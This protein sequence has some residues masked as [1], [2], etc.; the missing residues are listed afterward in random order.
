MVKQSTAPKLT[1]PKPQTPPVKPTTPSTPPSA[2]TPPKKIT[3][4]NT[5]AKLKAAPRELPKVKEEKDYLRKYQVR[6]QTE[7]GS[8]D[9]NPP[10]GSKAER[11]KKQLLLQ[12]KIRM[13]IPRQP[14]ED[15]TIDLSVTLNGYRLDFPKDTYIEVPEQIAEVLAESL[16]QTNIALSKNLIDGDKDKEEALR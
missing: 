8:V 9:S 16:K 12:D 10:K 2:S 6:K 4:A 7:A 13:L 11:M 15:K 5:P 1:P 3:P 14:D